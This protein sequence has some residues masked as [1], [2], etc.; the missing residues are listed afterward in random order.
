MNPR[1][2]PPEEDETMTL[3]ALTDVTPRSLPL[4]HVPPDTPPLSIAPLDEWP[5]PPVDHPE[6]APFR[7]GRDRR[8]QPS[9]RRVQAW[10]DLIAG[11]GLLLAGLCS[12]AS[13]FGATSPWFLLAVA[14][15]TVTTTVSA[16]A[17]A[18]LAAGWTEWRAR[19]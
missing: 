7:P 19:R 10:A 17:C 14:R 18:L 8:M 12:F 16:Y 1:P 6:P 9:G 2:K 11:I 15:L 4:L 3:P 13:I 5:D